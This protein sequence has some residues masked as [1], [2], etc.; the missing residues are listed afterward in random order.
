VRTLVDV[1]GAAARL[2]IDFGTFTTV[3]VV[4][5][6]T[7]EPRPLLFDGSPLLRS[8]VCVDPAGRLMAGRDAL[9]LAMANPAGFEPYP[10]RCVDD[11]TVLLDDA[12]VPMEVLFA[13]RNGPRR[14]V[15]CSFRNRW[16]RRT[17]TPITSTYT[18]RTAGRRWSTTS[19]PAHS[20]RRSSGVPVR[21]LPFSPP[22]ACPTLA[23]WT[24]T[25][26]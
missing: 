7:G 20:T 19:V 8:A 22:R 16:R 9:H 11:G 17:R 10:K 13:S 2:G 4:A 12:E 24:S 25:R 6:G 14:R 1:T 15:R 18:S 23:G 21:P 5:V 3:A 26:L